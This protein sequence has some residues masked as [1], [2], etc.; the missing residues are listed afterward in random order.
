ML[1]ILKAILFAK[2]VFAGIIR[3]A[4][5]PIENTIANRNEFSDYK[6]SM[7][8]ETEVPPGGYVEIIFPS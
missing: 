5:N 6:F 8:P 7:I 2:F 3:P 4:L 1:L